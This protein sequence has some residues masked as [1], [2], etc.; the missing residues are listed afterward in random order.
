MQVAS[1]EL[2]TKVAME[3]NDPKSTLKPYSFGY[4]STC[5]AATQYVPTDFAREDICKEGPPV[6]IQCARCDHKFDINQS[7]GNFERFPYY[8]PPERIPENDKTY[9]ISAFPSKE[10]EKEIQRLHLLEH[11]KKLLKDEIDRHI[12]YIKSETD[13]Q[14]RELN[15]LSNNLAK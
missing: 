7:T 8:T 11:Q 3:L 1:V 4:C 9:Y 10:I 2:Y 13:R 14:L 12:E 5:K 6:R 15:R